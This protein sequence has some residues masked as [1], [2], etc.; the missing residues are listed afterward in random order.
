MDM[1][2]LF[3]SEV[4]RE[5]FTKVFK[6]H[7]FNDDEINVSL[8]DNKLYVAPV[9]LPSGGQYCF[10]IEPDASDNTAI[11]VLLRDGNNASIGYN[12]PDFDSK[13]KLSYLLEH[14]INNYAH[15][16]YPKNSAQG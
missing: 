1:R 5:A 4:V 8:A 6:N 7:G 3:D 2:S 12:V 11:V 14:I 10:R 13:D 16:F 15:D 9:L